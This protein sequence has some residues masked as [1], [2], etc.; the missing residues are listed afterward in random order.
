MTEHSTTDPQSVG[1]VQW[2]LCGW[3]NRGAHEGMERSHPSPNCP[4]HQRPQP[5]AS[6]EGD[7][8]EFLLLLKGLF[9]VGYHCGFYDG[10]HGLSGLLIPTWENNGGGYWDEEIRTALLTHRPTGSADGDRKLES[11][12]HNIFFKAFPGYA[13]TDAETALDL[14]FAELQ[15]TR[16]ER[17][18]APPPGQ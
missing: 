2:C 1:G 3:K 7:K 14:L 12:L 9:E 6:V 17:R 4:V 18:A 8:E 11:R 13:W 15:A 10:K 5:E 16:V